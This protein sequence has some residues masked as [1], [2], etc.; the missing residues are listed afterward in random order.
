M[1]TILTVTNGAGVSVTCRVVS[2]GPFVTGRVIDIAKSTFS[3]LGPTSR[4]LVAVGV[5]W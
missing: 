1:G 5:S 3:K 4:G 2:T